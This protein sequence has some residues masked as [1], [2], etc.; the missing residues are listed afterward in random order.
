MKYK[1]HYNN[2]INLWG[3]EKVRNIFKSV[4]VINEKLGT[5]K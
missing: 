4:Q 5:E 1:K 3:I 2:I